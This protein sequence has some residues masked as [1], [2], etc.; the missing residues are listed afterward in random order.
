MSSSSGLPEHMEDRVAKVLFLT[1]DGPDTSYLEGLFLPIFE[2]L[3]VDGICFHILQFTWA[4]REATDRRREICAAAGIAYDAV[5]T[6]RRPTIA[7][8]ALLTA[9]KGTLITRKLLRLHR[10][11]IVMPRSVLPAFAAMRAMRHGV[12][13]MVFDADGLPL[14]ERVDFAG[15]SPFGLLYRIQRDMEAEAVRRAKV[16]LT[17][18]ERAADILLARAGAGTHPSKFH[19]VGNG[20]DSALFSPADAFR[21]KTVRAKL[22][23]AQHAPLLIYA[24]SLGGQ[25]CLEAMLRLLALVRAS[26]PDSCLLI[27]TPNLNLVD[28]AVSSLPELAGFVKALSVP[29]PSVPWYL[30]CA[31][32]GLALR[33][34]TFSMQAVAP[35]KLGE[36][37]LCGVPVVA[38][39]GTG[40]ATET[41][42][43]DVAHLLGDCDSAADLA[44]AAHWFLDQVLANRAAYRK[45][46][47]SFGVK[48]FSLHAT[49]K[50]Y[51]CALRSALNE[52][53]TIA[54]EHL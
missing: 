23:I 26:R 3:M 12:A 22:D 46:C 38:S 52:D 34:A 33:R 54:A 19:V 14:D 50:Q 45:R 28:R 48:H 18:S 53:S 16:V 43:A 10:I 11:D 29:A 27:L 21:R 5:R 6:W 41:L 25:Y 47:R 9:L 35:I 40:D 7:V 36:Y 49:A 15:A 4:S 1:W 39:A 37:L 30:A 24:G 32:L 44:S 17:R 13:P 42:A 20:R 51:G 31:D 8:G 2:R